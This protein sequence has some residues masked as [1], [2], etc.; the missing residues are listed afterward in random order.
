[1]FPT[2]LQLGPIPVRAYG[3]MIALSFSVGIWLG[4]K[5]SKP[6]GVDP[7]VFTDL[8]VAILISSI[9]GARLAYVIPFWDEYGKNVM[10]I[11]QVWEGGLTL[12]GG[13]GG[14]IVGSV[15]FARYKRISFWTVSDICSPLVALGIGI[16]RI[17]C[18]LNGCCYGTPTSFMTG[19]V[20]P[21]GCAAGHEY[22][23]VR[24]HPT[25]LY[26]SAFG[27][28]LFAFLLLIEKKI[29]GDG[30]IFLLFMI[31]YGLNRYFQDML[32]YYDPRALIHVGGWSLSGTQ[33]V[34]I[35]LIAAG[36]LLW[37]SRGPRRNQKVR[38]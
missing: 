37:K 29:K 31:L 7:V 5:R 10:S 24:I 9:I 4:M 28:L 18:F 19:I 13:I 26:D 16:T 15:L 30:R 32:R 23:G 36:L 33:A 14:A 20:F 21:G 8:C 22:P 25:Q 1:M 11:F 27:F 3:V 12:Y 6:R 34:S 38:A 35:G 17:G 2:I